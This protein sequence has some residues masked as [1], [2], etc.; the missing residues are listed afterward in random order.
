MNHRAVSVAAKLPPPPRKT[1]L[2][3]PLELPCFCLLEC[4]ELNQSIPLSSYFSGASGPSSKPTCS[5]A[6]TFQADRSGSLLV[7]KDWGL[8][9]HQLHSSVRGSHFP[10]ISTTGRQP[11][12][13]ASHWKQMNKK[14]TDP[15]TNILSHNTPNTICIKFRCGWAGLFSSSGKY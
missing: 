15:D 3:S 7:S 13:P 12:Q 10:L 11:L 2:P 9:L 8:P 1:L 6:Q 14:K 4:E 5:K